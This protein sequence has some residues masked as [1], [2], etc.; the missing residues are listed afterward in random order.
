MS[1]PFDATLK[2]IVRDHAA[3]FAPV[4]GLPREGP[5]TPL[6]VDLSTLSAA[7]DVALGYGDPLREVVDVNFQSGPDPQIDWRLHLYNAALGNHFH[8]PVQSLLILLRPAADHPNTTGKRNYG[9]GATRVQFNYKVIRL[10]QRPV[11]PFLRGGLG[12]LPLAPLCQLPPGLPVE[13]ALADLVR[14][15]GR[16]LQAEAEPADAK[17]LVTGAYILTGLRVS[18]ETAGFIFRG[19]AGMEESSTYQHILQLGEQK[20]QVRQAQRSLLRQGRQRFG[21]PAAATE[22][23][24]A[25]ITDLDRL[26]RMTDV[27]LTAASWDELLATP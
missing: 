15:M 9:R 18:Y 21:K 7:T 24:L 20:G 16:R 5:V 25:A 6:N 19:V 1:F 8:V 17:R 4:F 13:D 22:A 3:E 23:A 10:W 11:K 14:R 12:L 26:D 27:I 2:D